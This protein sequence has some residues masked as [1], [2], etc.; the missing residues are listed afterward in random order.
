MTKITIKHTDL[1]KRQRKYRIKVK[2]FRKTIVK[3][4]NKFEQAGLDELIKKKAKFIYESRKIPYI[5]EA[6]YIPDVTLGN[7][8]IIEFKGKFDAI[9][10]RKMAAVKA[11]N[12]ELDIRFV[13]YN[14]RSKIA[15]GS[16]MTHGEWAEKMGFKYSHQEIPDEWINE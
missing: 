3:G 1:V 2:A 12:P 10:R 4:R 8:I 6:N 13:F 16:R 9:A 11:C 5:I 14:S 15:K 7:G